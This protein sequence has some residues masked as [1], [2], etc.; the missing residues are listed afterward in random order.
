MRLLT[1]SEDGA[2]G[3]L[4]F[5]DYPSSLV[6][7]RKALH[8]GSHGGDNWISSIA[9]QNFE[10][11]SPYLCFVDSSGEVCNCILYQL[12]ICIFNAY[13]AINFVYLDPGG[14]SWSQRTVINGS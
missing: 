2:E 7:S 6:P 4:S 9:K 11:P 13:N 3:A 10:N 12:Y 5:K 8:L 1:S 14:E